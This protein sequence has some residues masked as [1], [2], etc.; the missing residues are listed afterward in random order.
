MFWG[1]KMSSKSRDTVH[2][3]QILAHGGITLVL[4]YIHV[5]HAAETAVIHFF[6]K[7]HPPEGII[8]VQLWV[9]TDYSLFPSYSLFL[10][11]MTP[12]IIV[13]RK[14]FGLEHPQSGT[15]TRFS[16]IYRDMGSC[17]QDVL[18]AQLIPVKKLLLSLLPP[19]PVIQR[20]PCS[21]ILTF[22]IILWQLKCRLY[23]RFR[24]RENT[25]IRS[26]EQDLDNNAE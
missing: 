26:E 13:Q 12:G 4:S 19:L 8:Q 5:L 16:T 24:S 20:R 6:N 10:K 2:G 1:C 21:C 25:L 23:R 14:K 18:A 22:D 15:C 11:H 7:V 9:R 3:F 17:V